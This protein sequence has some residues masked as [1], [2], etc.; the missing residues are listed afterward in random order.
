M[1]RQGILK[2]WPELLVFAVVLYISAPGLA[3]Y[4]LW[5]DEVETAERARSVLEQG[6]PQVLD[7]QG[8][9]SLNAGGLEIEDGELHRFTPPVQFYVGALGLAAGR[10]FQANEDL[11]IR[12]PFVVAHALTSSVVLYGLRTVG[13]VGVVASAVPALLF[14]AQSVRLIYDRTARYHALLDLALALGLLAL[15]RYRQGVPGWRWVLAGVLVVLPQ[16]H[17]FGGALSV[18]VLGL[19]ALYVIVG[20]GSEQRLPLSGRVAAYANWVV[21]PGLL[22]L[23]Q[24]TFYARPWLQQAWSTTDF[25][26]PPSVGDFFGIS[27]WLYV[28]SGAVVLLA[29]AREYARTLQLG[30]FLALYYY[31]IVTLDGLSPFSQ[32]RYY[33]SIALFALFWIVAL[34]SSSKGESSRRL[35]GQVLCGYAVLVLLLFEREGKIHWKADSLYAGLRAVNLERDRAAE[36][37]VIA[38]ERIKNEGEPTAPVLIDYVPQ[39]VNWYLRGHRVAL[40]PD[41]TSRTPLNAANLL[42]QRELVMPEWHLWYPSWGSG[43]WSCIGKCDFS[44]KF[45]DWTTRSYELSSRKLNQKVKM[46]V[47]QTWES[48]PWDNAPFRF[49]DGFNPAFKR[50]GMLAL[51]RRCP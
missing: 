48:S 21:L 10:L 36:P 7:A 23:A 41:S 28:L 29:F 16:I 18:V 31:G 27:F 13:G 20:G 4:P 47:L 42:M 44:V 11:A 14:G 3:S 26:S 2:L 37:L 51:A 32:S 17:T 12:S 49:I 34:G 6:L 39:Y 46:C 45:I 40:V 19:A 33:F 30:S 15:G 43:F 35:L 22:S 50:E 24:V 38:I 8:E 5:Q 1:A 9:L 25:V